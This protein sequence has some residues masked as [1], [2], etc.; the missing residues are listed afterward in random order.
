MKVVDISVEDVKSS[1]LN[2]MEDQQAKSGKPDH[3]SGGEY[4]SHNPPVDHSYGVEHKSHKTPTIINY[5]DLALS[6]K[7]KN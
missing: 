1:Q 4:K 2:Q 7:S 6:M 3:S 5:D